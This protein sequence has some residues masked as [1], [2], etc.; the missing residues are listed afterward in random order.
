M[1]FLILKKWGGLFWGQRRC[2]ADSRC[3][4]GEVLMQLIFT[5][6]GATTPVKYFTL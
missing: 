3:M 6:F 4:Q 1:A 5:T 2:G